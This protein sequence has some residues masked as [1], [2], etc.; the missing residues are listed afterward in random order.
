MGHHAYQ[1]LRKGISE[2]GIAA[3]TAQP[4]P[5]QAY[6]A[7]ETERERDVDV[8]IIHISY[9]VPV[10]VR[11]RSIDDLVDMTGMWSGWLP[12]EPPSIAASQ[13][14]TERGE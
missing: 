9:V 3:L 10:F 2:R 6:L 14:Q 12:S 8:K 13:R 11:T 1:A 7:A 4:R 5:L